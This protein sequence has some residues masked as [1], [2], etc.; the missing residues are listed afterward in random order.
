MAL[1]LV[2][3][4]RHGEYEERFFG[5]N[6]IYITW[7]GLNRDLSRCKSRGDVSAVLREVYPDSGEN[8][9]ENHA[10][11]LWAFVHQMK[12]GDWLVIPRKTKSA[13][14]VAEIVGPYEFDPNADDPYYHH[15]EVRWVEQDVPRSNFKQDLLYSFGAF[16]TICRIKRNDAEQR[17]RA[18]A[19][20][21]WGP[22]PRTEPPGGGG[23]PGEDNGGEPADLEQL[24]RDAIAKLV[25]QKFKGHGLALLVAAILEAEGYHTYVSPPGPDKGVDILAAPGSLGFGTPKLCVQVKS[26]EG[27]LDRPTLDQLIGV[28]QNFG[29]DQGLLV[30]WGGFKSSVDRE[31]A[32]QFFQVR[33]WDADALIEQL[34]EQYDRLPAEIR[35]ELPL[36]R[37]WTVASPEEES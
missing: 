2:R 23:G 16:L 37:I 3:A 1:W 11:Q 32:S 20:N 27:P 26:G 4:G 25:I 19:K 34:L 6:R 5:T 15:R 29:A 33:L 24:A 31:T 10:R 18:M 22:E 35:A 12:P 21:N 28:M 14:T 13:I 30:S 36:K 9:L 8:K 17:V 7:N